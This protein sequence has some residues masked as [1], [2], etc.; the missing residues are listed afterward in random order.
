MQVVP[1]NVLVSCKPGM[2][3]LVLSGSATISWLFVPSGPYSSDLWWG[4]FIK[5]SGSYVEEGGGVLSGY[6]IV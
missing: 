2:S 1:Q 6:C 4:I 5:G 3:N